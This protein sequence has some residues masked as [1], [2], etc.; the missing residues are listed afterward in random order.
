MTARLALTEKFSR[1]DSDPFYVGRPFFVPSSE[2]HR[3]ERVMPTTSLNVPR[4]VRRRIDPT[5]CERDYS[6]DEVEFMRAVDRYKRSTGRMFPTTSELLEV[7]RSLGY[8]KVA[9]V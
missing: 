3:Q 6:N 4:V 7:L 2:I 9:A 8:S 5:T 1:D